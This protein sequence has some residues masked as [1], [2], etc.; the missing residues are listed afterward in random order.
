[1]RGREQS[2]RRAPARPL[3]TRGERSKSAYPSGRVRGAGL[4]TGFAPQSASLGYV[5]FSL[6]LRSN[7]A[8]VGFFFSFLSLSTPSELG[9]LNHKFHFLSVRSFCNNFF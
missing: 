4:Q 9:P 1:M 2:G 3:P 7:G 5:K 6:P 8:G